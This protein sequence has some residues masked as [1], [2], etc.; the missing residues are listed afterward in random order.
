MPVAAACYALPWAGPDGSH[1]VTRMRKWLALATVSMLLMRCGGGG[2]PDAGADAGVDA[3][4]DAGMGGGAGGGAGGG[5]G[6]VVCTHVVFPESSFRAAAFVPQQGPTLPDW[7][8]AQFAK[9][10]GTDGG[11]D[12]F[13]IELWFFGN[14]ANP[15]FPYD[16][17]LGPTSYAAC[18]VCLTYAEG[19]DARGEGCRTFFLAQ[20]GRVS[21]TKADRTY[22]VGE[23]AGSGTDIRF[24]EWHKEGD[25]A[26]PGGRCVELASYTLDGGWSR[27][28]PDGGTDAGVEDGGV[29][30]GADGG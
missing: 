20:S 22:D 6:S 8:W 12:T 11:F 18:E 23:F 9:P 30:A 17:T 14:S 26:I 1:V 28:R 19:C 27:A 21:F 5:G 25:F 10:D 24:I 7:V 2:P 3:G 13:G 29:D 15:T 16:V 4:A